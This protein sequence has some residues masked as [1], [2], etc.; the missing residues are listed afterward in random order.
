MHRPGNTT[1]A[2]ALLAAGSIAVSACGRDQADL[3]NGKTLFVNKCGACHTLARANA[4]GTQGPNLDHAFADD[5]QIGMNSRTI[6]GVVKHQIGFPLH[7]SIM[8]A[9]LVTGQNADDVA[10]YVGYAAG[11]PGKDTGT[12]AEAGA[13]KTSGKP[14]VETSGKLTIP[15]IDG[16]LFEFTKAEA[17]A[18]KVTVEMPNKS[19]IPH[20]IAIPSI[21]GA[22]GKIVAKGSV[23]SFSI[24]LKPGTYQY[25]CEVPG[26]AQAGMKGTITVK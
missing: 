21:P 2:I 25:I 12:L 11:R 16:T 8:P 13:P 23:S 5:R 15:A 3:A 10:A 14:A 4:K 19:D 17:K 22:A 26:H 6:K 7:G 9:N 24:N 1:L 18:G 20:N